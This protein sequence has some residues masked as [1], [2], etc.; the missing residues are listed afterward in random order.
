MYVANISLHPVGSNTSN[1]ASLHN[2]SFGDFPGNTFCICFHLDSKCLRWFLFKDEAGCVCLIVNPN[3]LNYQN[4]QW[5]WSYIL[6]LCALEV[7]CC[8]KTQWKTHQWATLNHSELNVNSIPHTPSCCPECSLVQQIC[9]NLQL[10]IVPSK[11][12]SSSCL[13]NVD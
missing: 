11:L 7:C 4:Q 2:S 5:I 9:I 3:P 13:S 10:E 6:F 8:P 1:E 12:T